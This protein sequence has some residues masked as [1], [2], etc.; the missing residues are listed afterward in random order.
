MIR[1]MSSGPSGVA[2]VERVQDPR[3]LGVEADVP[4]PVGILDAGPRLDLGLEPDRWLS[5]ASTTR[6]KA[7]GAG[8]SKRK[9]MTVSKRSE[10]AQ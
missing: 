2:L 4:A 8:C 9:S 1:R 7:S 6:A 3:R 5:Q 10:R